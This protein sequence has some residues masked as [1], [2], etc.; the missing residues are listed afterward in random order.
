MI[1]LWLQGI[2]W[3]RFCKIRFRVRHRHQIRNSPLQLGNSNPN[4]PLLVIK[5]KKLPLLPSI[6]H[7]CRCSVL[8][9]QPASSTSL[10]A[11]PTALWLRP[12]PSPLSTRTNKAGNGTARSGR[13]RDRERERQEEPRNRAAAASRRSWFEEK[14]REE[15]EGAAAKSPRRR[16]RGGRAR[17]CAAGRACWGS[18]TSSPS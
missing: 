14:K 15:G 18:S 6:L 7:R 12:L 4:L 5:K 17:C 11:N 3:L 13:G 2:M 9:G 1:T 10:K 16:R 8:L